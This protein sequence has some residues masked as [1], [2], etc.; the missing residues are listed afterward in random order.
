MSD[1]VKIS[2][3]WDVLDEKAFDKDDDIFHYAKGLIQWVIDK[4]S[5]PA[6]PIPEGSTNGDM[7]KALFPVVEIF[8]KDEMISAT[9]SKGDTGHFQ[10]CHFWED[11]WNAPYKKGETDE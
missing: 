7:I 4:R 8:E 6:I 1:Y 5:V 2:D 3:I 10:K 11:W 9:I